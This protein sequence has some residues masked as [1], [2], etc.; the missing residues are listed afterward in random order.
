MQRDVDGLSTVEDDGGEVLVEEGFDA[1][2]LVATVQKGEESGVHSYRHDPIAV[3]CQR[4]AWKS[5]SIQYN[6]QTYLRWLRQ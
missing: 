3:P 4:L 2:D 1:D 5:I 6:C